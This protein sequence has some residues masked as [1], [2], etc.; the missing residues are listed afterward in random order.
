MVN[1]KIY[2]ITTWLTNNQIHILLN[3]SRSKGNQLMNL[4]TLQNITRKIFFF[5]NHAENE[6]R[7]L[8]PVLFVSHKS[9]I[10]GKSKWPYILIALNLIFNENKLWKTLDYWSRNMLKFDFF[11]K[12]SGNSFHHILFIIS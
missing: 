4:V 7:R 8:V 3:I 11:R 9:F 6:A 1:S 10:W 2:D 5:K 12:G